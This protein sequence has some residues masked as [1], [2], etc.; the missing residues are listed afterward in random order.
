MITEGIINAIDL[1]IEQCDNEEQKRGIISVRE[2]LCDFDHDVWDETE[3]S[4]RIE[5]LKSF[6]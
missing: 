6:L 2:M 3:Q 4:H 1:M 5:W